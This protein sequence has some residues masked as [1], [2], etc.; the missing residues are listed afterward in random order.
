MARKLLIPLSAAVAGALITAAPAAAVTVTDCDSLQSALNTESEST[1]TLAEGLTCTGSWD[2]PSGRSITLEGAGTGA[3]LDG[4]D[5]LRILSGNDHGTV[6]IRNITFTDG[7]SEGDGGAVYLAGSDPVT[8]ADSTFTGNHADGAGGAVMIETSVPSLAASASGRTAQG[9]EPADA[10]TLTRN[11]FGGDEGDGNTSSSTGGAVAAYV[12]GG[13]TLAGNEFLGNR[14]TG[15]GGGADV[16]FRGTATVSGNTFAGNTVVAN[17]QLART[18]SGLFG[19]F[20]AGGGLAIAGYDSV[21]DCGSEEAPPTPNVIEQTANAFRGNAAETGVEGRG[22]G[23]GEYTRFATL[24][25]TDDTFHA[26]EISDGSVGAGGGLMVTE[27]GDGGAVLRNFVA[28]GNTM[29]SG[30]GG[31]VGFA[32]FGQTLSIVHATIAGNAIGEGEGAGVWGARGQSLTLDNSIVHGNTGGDQ[33]TGFESV[34]DDRTTSGASIVT[35]V[36]VAFSDVC[37]ADGAPLAGEGN[38][39]AD[40]KLAG[41]AGGNVHQT[42]DSPTLDKASSAR[43]GGLTKD[44]EGQDRVQDYFR[45]GTARPDMGADEAP[46]PPQQQEQPATQQPAA[47]AAPAAGGV[48]GTQAKSCTSRRSFKIKL[49][50]RGQKV[51]KATVIVNG[52]RVRV[53]KGKRLTSRVNLRGLPK[54]RYSVQIK[55]ELANGKTISGVRKYFTCRPG[56]KS[57]PPKV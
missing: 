53:L 39:C 24:S 49:R 56:R 37:D 50:N 22:T 13:V 16:A 32:S 45:S 36:E 41:S 25:S 52:K 17:R 30:N 54:G 7:W 28:T 29:G 42:A 19:G 6:V 9:D 46:A 21:C 10:V 55:L 38:I 12:R 34:E 47:P 5:E 1:V 57:G 20:A 8:I 43:T 48:L 14:G 18:A 26:N 33:V 44:F 31:G 27:T 40:P 51:V 23:A 3:T 15:W 35:G 11:T 4:D 2:L